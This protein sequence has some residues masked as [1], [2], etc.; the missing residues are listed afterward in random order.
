MYIPP[1]NKVE[2]WDEIQQFVASVRAA[3][4]VTVNSS[5]LPVATLMPMVWQVDDLQSGSYGKL[6]MHM[7]R[8]NPQWKE[9]FP[10]TQALA[11][12]HGAQAYISPT[13]YENKITDHK[14]VPTW[15][16]QSVHLSGTV[17]ISEDTELLRQIVTDLTNAHES[18]RKLPWQVEESDPHYFELQLKGII[19]VILHVTKVEAKSKLSQNKSHEDRIRIVEDLFSSGI[20]GEE[21]IAVE[22]QREL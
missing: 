19:A 17:E 4:L 8:A 1:Q 6:I 12:L 2:D 13:N 15:N 10:G 11:I 3:D 16:Y 9:I 18:A 20:P 21:V 5:G 7:A 22:M 14:V